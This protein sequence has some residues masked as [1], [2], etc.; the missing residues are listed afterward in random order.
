MA[1]LAR[2]HPLGDNSWGHSRWTVSPV[3]VLVDFP[4]GVVS[5]GHVLVRAIPAFRSTS[6]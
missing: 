3:F 5:H 2:I 1:T 4:V 6:G